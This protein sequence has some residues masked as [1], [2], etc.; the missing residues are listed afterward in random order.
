MWGKYCC[1]HE[2]EDDV[3]ETIEA[4]DGSKLLMNSTCC[5]NH[6]QIKCPSKE[7][8]KSKRGNS[9][10]FISPSSVITNIKII[11]PRLKLKYTFLHIYRRKGF[12]DEGLSA[13]WSNDYYH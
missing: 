1:R 10:L 5:K 9:V 12:H 7:G 3:L 11:A 4:C 8:C 6:E 13:K 2:W